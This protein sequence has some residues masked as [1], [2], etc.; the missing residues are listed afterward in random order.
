MIYSPFFE[1]YYNN[2]SE[3]EILKFQNALL[4]KL[5]V[6]FLEDIDKCVVPL[7]YTYDTAAHMNDFGKD[8]YTNLIYEGLSTNHVG[9]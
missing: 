5:N 3:E 1:G 8:Y 7:E 6:T 4:E 9:E 2:P